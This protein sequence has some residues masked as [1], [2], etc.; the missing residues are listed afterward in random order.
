MKPIGRKLK[1][2]SMADVIITTLL[3]LF[4]LIVV[5]PFLNVVMISFTSE[6]EYLSAPVFLFPKHPTL[7]AYKQLIA[8][9]RI[10]IGYKNTL[11]ILVMSIPLSMFCTASFA[12]GISRPSFP[13]RKNIFVFVLFTMLFQGG[14]IPLYMQMK[15]LHLTNNLWSVVLA[16]TMSTFYMIILRN[17]FSGLPESLIESAK[18]DGAG[19]WGILLRIVLPLSMPVMATIILFYTVARWNEW[20]N[21]MIF[22]QSGRL[23][24]LQLVLRSIVIESRIDSIVVNPGGSIDYDNANFTMGL[25]TATIL[26]TMLPVMMVYPFL[27]KHFVKGILIGAVKS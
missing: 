23:Q 7:S 12:Y 9:G 22:L 27:Q 4:S 26:V 3:I 5:F 24:P 19:E 6:K 16:S 13:G 14:I 1:G 8:D 10:L 17:F 21:A 18:L 20:Y 25:K 2:I 15:D 11:L